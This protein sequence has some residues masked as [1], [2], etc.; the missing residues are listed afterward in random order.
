MD[1]EDEEYSQKID[2]PFTQDETNDNMFNEEFQVSNAANRKNDRSNSSS[3][4]RKDENID[5]LA[6]QIEGISYLLRNLNNYVQKTPSA[7][8]PRFSYKMNKTE[9]FQGIPELPEQPEEEDVQ[10]LPKKEDQKSNAYTLKTTQMSSKHDN[11][12]DEGIINIKVDNQ[13]KLSPKHKKRSL[14]KIKKVKR[15]FPNKPQSPTNGLK[16]KKS[17]SLRMIRDPAPSAGAFKCGT[18]QPSQWQSQSPT[19]SIKKRS[20][21]PSD[22]PRGIKYKRI[23]FKRMKTMGGPNEVKKQRYNSFYPARALTAQSG[24]LISQHNRILSAQQQQKF[25]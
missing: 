8:K 3:L 20:L 4:I 23:D 21:S 12:T 5:N 18:Y 17:Q 6:K 22:K 11:M 7:V 24:G 15:A 9:D 14:I 25:G 2:N 10:Y 13:K 16:L 19:V 1:Q